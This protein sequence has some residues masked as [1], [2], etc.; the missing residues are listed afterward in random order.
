M[1]RL[2]L[3]RLFWAIYD[4]LGTITAIS[5]LGGVTLW[6]ILYGLL[7]TWSPDSLP[8]EIIVRVFLGV[9]ALF[10]FLWWFCMATVLGRNVAVEE[11]I[12]LKALFGKARSFFVGAFTYTFTVAFGGILILANIRFYSLLAAELGGAYRLLASSAALLFIYLLICFSAYALALLGTWAVGHQGRF[13]GGIFRET[14]MH[15]S[16]LPRLWFTALLLWLL[17]AVL[18]VISVVGTVFIV[19]LWCVF[20]CVAFCTSAE[21]VEMLGVAKSELGEAQAL[22]LYRRRAVE[23]CIEREM[24]KPPRTWKDIFKPW[25]Y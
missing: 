8:A 4:F 10:C 3:H 17:I 5:F 22:K 23:L 16:L 19:P 15:L 24:R 11:A 6:L 1:T 18:L 13:G 7:G 12:R 25:E 21:F 20:G 9:L 2:F 14:L